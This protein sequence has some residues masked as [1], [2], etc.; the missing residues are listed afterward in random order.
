MIHKEK[1]KTKDLFIKDLWLV[2]Q[3]VW[4]N[5]RMLINTPNF[6][7]VNRHDQQL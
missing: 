6:L 3:G 1:L 7:S 2:T 5:N 4:L